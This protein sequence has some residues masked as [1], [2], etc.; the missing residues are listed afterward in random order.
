VRH[1]WPATAATHRAARERQRKNIPRERDQHLRE[2]KKEKE[3]KICERE[4][5]RGG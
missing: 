5:E 1:H 3:E 4:G 2:E